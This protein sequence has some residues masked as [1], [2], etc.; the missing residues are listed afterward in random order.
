MGFYQYA[1]RRGYVSKIPLPQTLPKRPPPFVPYI[2]SKQELKDLFYMALNYPINKSHISP[3]MVRAVLVL[4]Y[5]LGLR[6]HETVAITLGD[7][8]RENSVITIKE[9]KFYKSRLVPFNLQIK[10]F[11]DTYLEWRIKQHQA[12]LSE[13]PL[14][15]GKNN[16]AFNADTM[17]GIFQRIRQQA[18]I[19]RNDGARYQPRIHDLRHTF[20]VNRLTLWYKENENVQQLLPVLSVYLGHK[21]LVHTTAYLTMTDNLLHEANKRFERYITGEK[22]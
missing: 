8:D 21:Y 15:I 16:Q 11:I 1:L 7:I 3:V 19:K 5:A 6:L 18:G 2:Y 22:K 10:E 4:T 9:S 12:Q 14:F 17:R 20:A 13:A